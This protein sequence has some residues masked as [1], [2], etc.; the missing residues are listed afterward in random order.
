MGGGNS[1]PA[2]PPPVAAALAAAQQQQAAAQA[3]AAQAAAAQQQAAVAAQ[4]AAAA[5]AAAAQA[6]QQQ[7]QQ[8]AAQTQIQQR[9]PPPP[10]QNI[11][12]QQAVLTETPQIGKS[13]MVSSS[14]SSSIPMGPALTIPYMPPPYVLLEGPQAPH[15]VYM[16]FGGPDAKGSMYCPCGSKATV[17]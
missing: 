10:P 3:A 12:V 4:Q 5:Q 6:A 9:L 7:Q 16:N 8:Q 17:A 11:R 13:T 14:A 15:P 1:K 2:P